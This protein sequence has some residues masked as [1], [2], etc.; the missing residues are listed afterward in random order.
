MFKWKKLI[1]W[2]ALIATLLACKKDQPIVQG[3]SKIRLVNAYLNAD[4]QD[5]YQENSKLGEAV[6]YSSY[7]TYAEVNAGRSVIWTSGAVENKATAA[8]DV[9][10]YADNNY[11]LFYYE[12]KS[13]K[14][15]IVG[16]INQTTQPAAGKFK[17]RFVNLSVMF[18]DKPLVITSTTAT[19]TSG[20]NYGDNPTYTEFIVGTS[21]NVNVKDKTAI[22]ALDTEKFQSGKNYTVWFDSNDGLEVGYH[23][24]P[25]NI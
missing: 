13:A 10:L 4:P 6:A 11:T 5:L 18:N 20:L 25:E 1:I 22:T 9:V 3:K 17:V 21:L 8:T 2:T 7:G 14:P 16:Y 24:V 23:V 15:A 12:N 19:I